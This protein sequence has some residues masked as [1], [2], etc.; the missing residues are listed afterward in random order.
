MFANAYEIASIYTQPVLV[1]FR[2]FDGKIESGLGSFVII[3]EDGW[4]ITAAHILDSLAAVNQNAKEIQ[5]YQT[6]IAEIDSDV[7]LNAK[8]KGK[9][10]RALKSKPNWVINSSHWWGHDSHRINNF[11]VLKENDIAIGKIENYNPN[12]CK[13]YPVFKDPKNLKNGTSLCKLGYPFYD[14]KATFDDTANSFAFDPSIF[15][16]PRFPIDGIFTRN[17]LAG[18]SVDKKYDIKFIETSS[19]GLR[20]QSGGPI[21]DVNGNIWAIQSQTRHLPLGFSPKIKKGNKEIEENQFLNV[22]WGAHVETILNFLDANKIS[23][24]KT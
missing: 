14:V 24:L 17:I 19:P 23:Y 1:S 22:G 12:F 4:I 15:P 7:K 21:F 16:I 13:S 11:H 5:E 2:L 6:K 9:R 10:K 20:G 8:A 18:K 3:N